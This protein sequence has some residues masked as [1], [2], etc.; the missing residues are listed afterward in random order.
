MN[1]HKDQK[2]F[3]NANTG[4]N[5]QLWLILKYPASMKLKK[6]V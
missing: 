6:H 1:L 5:Y 3:A 4:Q 2:S